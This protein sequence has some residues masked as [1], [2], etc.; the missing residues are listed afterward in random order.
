MSPR[1]FFALLRR[2]RE[3]REEIAERE[4]RSDY[5]AALIAT[6]VLNAA[7]GKQDGQPFEVW[8]FFAHLAPEPDPDADAAALVSALKARGARDL[9]EL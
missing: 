4:K 2:R 9:R 8:D 5:R 3:L 7:G 1:E 6:A